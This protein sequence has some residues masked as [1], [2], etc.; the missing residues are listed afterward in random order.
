MMKK[1]RFAN[2]YTAGTDPYFQWLCRKEDMHSVGRGYMTM[3]EHLHE[4][5][6]KPT[7]R[8]AMDSNRANDGL[9]LRVQF[10]E[11]YGELGSSTNRGPCTMLEFLI[12]VAKRMSFL[13]GGENE[14]SKTKEYFWHLIK[15]LRLLKLDD[16]RYWELNG[17]FFVDDAVQ[18][19]LDRT[20]GSDGNGGL[21][22][23]RFPSEDQRGVD[24]WMQM[25]AWLNEHCTINID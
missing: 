7:V 5:I 8:N 11:R 1:T 25:H 19:V 21:F 23:L 12:G 6:F 22:P 16:E 15:N 14:P 20:Y 4:L 18:R 2:G 24:I 10:M 17:E 13:M 3:A 9:Q